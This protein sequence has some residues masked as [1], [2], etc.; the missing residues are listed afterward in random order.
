M[1][2]KRPKSEAPPSIAVG[3]LQ[4]THTIAAN[5]WTV[6]DA[7]RAIRMLAITRHG[8]SPVHWGAWGPPL[9]GQAPSPAAPAIEGDRLE[10]ADVIVIPGWLVATGPELRKISGA[11][12]CQVGPL[13]HAHLARGGRILA[14]FNGSALLA[15]AG[16]LAGRKAA[17]PWVFAPSIVLQSGHAVTWCRERTWCCDGPL[18][19]TA[20]LPGTL[21]AFIDLLGHTSAA[22]AA[23]A[24]GTALLYDGGRQLTATSALETPTNQP[25]MAGALERA[26]QWLQAHRHQPYD[27]AATARAAATSPRTLLRWFAQVHGQTPLDYLHGL[28]AAQ[29]QTLLQTTYL[30]VEAIAHQCGYADVGNFR[31]MFRRHAGT[32]P[33]A[34]RRRFQLRSHRKQWRGPLI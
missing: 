30:T 3:I 23:Q 31:Q 6:V 10:E 12:S 24:V 26:R 8:R 14:L 16:L 4:S 17:L 22:E 29:A 2:P 27:L 9:E 18:W 13:L 32:T 33:G 15:E 34:Y 19:S 20:A 21:E 1:P 28:R 11:V 5:V 25:L 7:L